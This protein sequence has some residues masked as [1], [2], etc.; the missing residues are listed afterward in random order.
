M[1]APRAAGPAA[2]QIFDIGSFSTYCDKHAARPLL[3][4][5]LRTYVGFGAH[6]CACI[7]TTTIEA[8]FLPSFEVANKFRLPDV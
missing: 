2:F 8:I 1:V 6:H 7:A 3:S 4:S 5:S